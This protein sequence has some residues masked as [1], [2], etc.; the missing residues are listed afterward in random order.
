MSTAYTT[1]Q[2]AN[3]LG[4]PGPS[5]RHQAHHADHR[6]RASHRARGHVGAARRRLNGINIPKLCATDSLEAFGSCRLCL[7][8]IEG[9][10]GF[11]A[12]CTTK[13]SR[14]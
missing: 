11:P 10:K 2:R 9:M 5:R 13:P 1:Y 12:S 3:D 4:T 7:V 6:R 8:Q 14:A